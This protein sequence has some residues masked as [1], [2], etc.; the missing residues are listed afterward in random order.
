MHRG[1]DSPGASRSRRPQT[2]RE[3]GKQLLQMMNSHIARFSSGLSLCHEFYLEA[4]RPLL[5]RKFPGLPH[6]AALIGSGSEVLGFDDEMSTD[7]HWGPRVMLFLQ[8]GDHKQLA[9]PIRQ[10]MADGLPY[11]FR[12]YPTN[13]TQP[14][15]EDNNTQLLHAID[16]GPVNHRVTTHTLSGFF[17]EYLNFDLRQP[18]RPADWLSFPEQHLLSVTAGAVYHDQVGL[19]RVRSRFKYYPHDVWLYLLAAGWARIG[20]DEH[21]MG[22]AGI[23]GD[24]VGSA[25]IGAR[26]VRDVMRLCFLMEKRYA[27]YPKWFGTGFKQLSCAPL[28]LPSLEGALQSKN[29]QARESHLVVAYQ[30]IATLH[31][32]LHLTE[33]L[34]VE[35][36]QFFGRPFRVIALNGFSD[37]I[38]TQIGDPQVKRIAARAPIGSID[39]FSDSTDLLSDP[40]WRPIVRHLYE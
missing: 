26:L 35:P 23:A 32:A 25:L 21:L 20:Q 40:S 10:T 9:E 12:G 13:F 38:L 36:K 4:V 1:V 37:A 5:D 39:Q 29:W 6:A 31:N 15:P 11:T 16:R 7:H 2:G 34:P 30:V 33:P 14:N 22:R 27:P 24:E 3:C 17:A 28:L 18:I 8:E 19:E